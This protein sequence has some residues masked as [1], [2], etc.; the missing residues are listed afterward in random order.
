MM[1][2]NVLARNDVGAT[3]LDRAREVLGSVDGVGKKVAALLLQ[4]AQPWSETTHALFPD[5]DR[6]VAVDAL[7]IAYEFRKTTRFS[8]PME[9]WRDHILPHLVRRSGEEE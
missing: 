6:R 8:L 3:P 1:A 2:A 5:A 9:L 4:A 7:R